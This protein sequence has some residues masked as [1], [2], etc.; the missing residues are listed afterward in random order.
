MVS[1]EISQ[2][3][4][5]FSYLR[6][7]NG[8]MAA[9]HFLLAAFMLVAGLTVTNIKAFKLPVIYYFQ[10]YDESIDR[11]VLDSKAI[12]WCYGFGISFPFRY[13]SFSGNTSRY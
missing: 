13:S 5:S 4:I 10:S 2:S 8:V 7:F 11:L 6:K 1:Q 9:L 12:Y 3:I